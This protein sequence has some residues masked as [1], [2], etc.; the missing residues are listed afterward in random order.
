MMERAQAPQRL[1][2]TASSSQKQTGTMED[3]G[4]KEV[5]FYSHSHNKIYLHG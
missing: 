3:F 1:T 2:I 4:G 5:P